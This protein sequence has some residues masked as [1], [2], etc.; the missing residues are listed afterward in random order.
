MQPHRHGVVVLAPSYILLGCL[1]WHFQDPGM[2]RNSC[3]FMGLLWV[4]SC[5]VGGD[6][7]LDWTK[8][9]INTVA[10]Y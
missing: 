2:L 4:P 1:L 7:G 5:L 8:A 3:H 6:G 9:Q 10:V